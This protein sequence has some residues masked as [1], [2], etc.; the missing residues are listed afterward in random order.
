MARR[1]PEQDL[2]EIEDFVRRH[3]DG[4]TFK[5]IADALKTRVPPR[6]LQYRLR[7][8]VN[9]QRLV[10]EGDRRW[11]KY[12]TRQDQ[13]IEVPSGALTLEPAIPFPPSKAAID[14][15]KYLLQPVTARKPV[16]YNR[17]F[18]E[19]YR[20]NVT[21]YLSPAERARL[22]DAGNPNTAQQP[23]G[24]YRS[25]VEFKPPRRK[26]LLAARHATPHRVWP[27]A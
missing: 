18:L 21:A 6:T 19:S 1:I 7:Y 9:E 26:H 8:L 20:P 16:G 27:A 23:A 24:T 10:P 15:Q 3:P 25:F 4:V 22:R 13:R 14:I 5:E 17:D 12:R 11:R 2:I